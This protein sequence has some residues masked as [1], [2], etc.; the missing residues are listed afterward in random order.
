MEIV[1]QEHKK[2]LSGAVIA[3]VVVLSLYFAMKFVSE[4]RAYSMG[5]SGD[6]N[7]ITM[8]GYGEVSAVPDVANVRFTI[9]KEAKTVAEAQEAVAEQEAEVL[10]FLRDSE[11][12]ERDI[13]TTNVSFYP[14]Y[15]V[16]PGDASLR[17][18]NEFYCPPLPSKT[19]VVGYVASE[20]ITVKVRNVDNVGEIT[21]GLGELGI[22]QLSGPDFTIDDED[23]LKAQ[24][25]KDAIDD[26]REKAEVLADD[27]G[28][29]LGRVVTF[30]ESDYGFPIYAVRNTSLQE[31]AADKAMP[32][33]LPAGENIVS[34]NVTITYEIR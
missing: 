29:R 15:E 18:C 31:G 24:A 25:R 7:T 27:L 22:T 5:G 30:T 32:P 19:V 21:Q 6:A 20:S 8:S 28:V 13:K 9:E 10:E 34:S 11:I 12:E 16:A 33:E 3:L 2:F 14:K 1:T 23:A 26:A 4:I 17:P